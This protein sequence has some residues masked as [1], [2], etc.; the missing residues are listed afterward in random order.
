MEEGTEEEHYGRGLAGGVTH[1][2]H[3][4]I[5]MTHTPPMHRHVPGPPKGVNIIGIP[6]ITVKVAIRKV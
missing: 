4:D 2:D 6:P 5:E 1:L 3:R